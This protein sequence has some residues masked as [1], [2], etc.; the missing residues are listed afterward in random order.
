[1]QGIEKRDYCFHG[2]PSDVWAEAFHNVALGWEEAGLSSSHSLLY[3]IVPKDG[4]QGES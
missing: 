2:F 3:A 4:V 1:M